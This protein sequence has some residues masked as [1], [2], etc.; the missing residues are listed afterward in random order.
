MRRLSSWSALAVILFLP[1]AVALTAPISGGPVA[2]AEGGAAAGPP[3]QVA[4]LDE[5]CS[6]CHSIESHGIARKS[7]SDKMKGPDLSTIGD[8]HDAKWI[9]SYIERKTE[10]DGEKHGKP[11]KGSAKDLADIADWLARLKA[12]G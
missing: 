11:Y 5:G 10:L 8:K 7:K 6:T 4:F 9:V 2:A 3:G 1:L 12:S